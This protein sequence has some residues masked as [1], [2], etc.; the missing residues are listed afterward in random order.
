MRSVV[1]ALHVVRESASL[2]LPSCA[3]ATLT[4]PSR[5]LVF[6]PIVPILRILRSAVRG[7]ARGRIL[8]PGS[9]A[10]AQPEPGPY[11]VVVVGEGG[12]AALK[13]ASVARYLGGGTPRSHG[14]PWTE[15]TGQV[16]K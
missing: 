11:V 4:S 13:R 6:L 8:Y 2:S 10:G 14:R 9:V 16:S 15:G 1:Q 3:G 5:A 12:S 7:S